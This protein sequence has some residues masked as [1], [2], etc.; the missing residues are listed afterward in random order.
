MLGGGGGGGGGGDFHFSSKCADT[1][2]NVAG[3]CTTL[4]PTQSP[5]Q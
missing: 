1:T 2:R 3:L 4:G 5:V